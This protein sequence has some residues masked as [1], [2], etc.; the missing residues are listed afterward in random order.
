MIIEDFVQSTWGNGT[1]TM[2][3]PDILAGA[4]QGA[5]GGPGSTFPLYR[6]AMVALG[7][8]VALGLAAWLRFTRVGLFVRAASVNPTIT[9]VQGVNTDRL[10][11]IVVGL[12]AALAGVS[13]V[14]AAPLLALSPSMAGDILVDSFIVVVVGG[15]GSL[16]GAFVAALLIGQIHVLGIIFVPELTALLPFMLMVAVLIWKPTGLSGTRV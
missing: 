15:L 2:P 14:V 4:V 12:G 16:V 6:L 10:S 9:A 7:A 3:V 5:G 11:A 13:G 8:I 1:L